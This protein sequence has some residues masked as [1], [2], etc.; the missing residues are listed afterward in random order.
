MNIE[1]LRALHAHLSC[2]DPHTFDMSTWALHKFLCE[3][4]KRDCNV[5]FCGNE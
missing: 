2:I 4:S 1:R 3:K 5:F